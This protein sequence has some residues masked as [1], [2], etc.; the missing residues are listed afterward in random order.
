MAALKPAVERPTLGFTLIEVL[1][2]ISLLSLLMLSA[3]MAYGFM[4]QNWQRNQAG[5]EQARSHYVIWQLTSQTLSNTYP[6]IVYASVPEL[7]GP[8]ANMQLGFYFLGR[9]NGYTAV[10]SLSHQDPESAAVYRLFKEPDPDAIGR[11]QLVYEEALLNQQLL[12]HAEQ[13]L[14][15]NY[16]RVLLRQQQQITF[17]Y[18]GWLSLRDLMESQTDESAATPDWHSE[19]DG[20]ATSLH[21]LKLTVVTDDV[22][23]QQQ[24]DA[25]YQQLLQQADL[26]I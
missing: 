25:Q 14:P 19:Y 24:F 11:W 26:G 22:S 9:E 4:Q 20:L 7:T 6:K 12:R 21:P 5:M 17:S 13:Q 2:S 16:R 8:S 3:L 1:L 18:Q 23:W 15:F 10:T